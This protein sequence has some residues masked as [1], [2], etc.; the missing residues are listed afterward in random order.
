MNYYK[1]LLIIPP[2]NRT[3]EIV[4]TFVREERVF[5]SL[6]TKQD[7]YKIPFLFLFFF[8]VLLT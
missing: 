1:L 5:S 7:K 4:L 6:G 8:W 3:S 2:V